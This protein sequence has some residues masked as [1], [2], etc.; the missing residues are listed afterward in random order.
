[1]EKDRGAIVG[2]QEGEIFEGEAQVREEFLIL[3]A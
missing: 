2:D 1:M 3:G